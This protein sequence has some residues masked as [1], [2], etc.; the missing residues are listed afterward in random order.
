MRR[1]IDALLGRNRDSAARF[2][3]ADMNGEQGV[4]KAEDIDAKISIAARHEAGHAVVAAT[5][6]LRL[7]AE[8]I[9]VDA[10]AEG[11]AC[12]CKQPDG[13]D[14]SREAII[15][16]TFA[17]CYAENYFRESEGYRARDYATIIGSGDWFEAREI[18]SAF[19]DEY[20]AGRIVAVVQEILERRS[21]QLVAENW[22]A[23]DAL[24]KVLIANEWQALKP[25]K[26]GGRWSKAAMAKY[27]TGAEL[28]QILTRCG[29]EAVCVTEC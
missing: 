5:L 2:I 24:A 22:P 21:M 11:L 7:R 9:M 19:S 16:T 28:V 27:V 15:L 6:G 3:I 26:S 23:I 12:Y 25:L 20:R 17:G 14:S 4:V 1:E 13:S 29:I 8:G 18:E 10:N